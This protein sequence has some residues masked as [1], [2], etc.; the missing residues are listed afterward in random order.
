M[1]ADHVLANPEMYNE[2]ILGAPPEE[3]S[4]TIQGKDRWGGAI[5]LS[6]FSNIFNLEICTFDVKVTRLPD[7]GALA[8]KLTNSPKQEQNLVSFGEGKELRCILLYSGIH[9]DRVAFSLSEPPYKRSDLPPEMDIVRWE[10]SD[11]GIIEKTRELVT[12]LNKIHYYTDTNEIL[13]R[14]E[15]CDWIG[16]G[17]LDGRRH[18]ELTGHTQ[19]SEIEDG[20]VLTCNTPGCDWVGRGEREANKHRI[21]T[22]HPSWSVIPDS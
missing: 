8:L 11:D 7:P 19:L 3:Y 1:V 5:E 18:A 13:L 14:C 12:C 17:Q 16:S 21:D 2:G 20:A 22:G 15:E 6:I 10:T 9:Y 4:R